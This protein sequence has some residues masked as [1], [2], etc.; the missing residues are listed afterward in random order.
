MNQQGATQ[1]LAEYAKAVHE[2]HSLITA[3]HP[4]TVSRRGELAVLV[5]DW[6]VRGYEEKRIVA[7]LKYFRES[8]DDK[9]YSDTITAFLRD[10]GKAKKVQS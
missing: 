8:A 10:Y 9:V 1:A 7:T 3:M 2:K 5:L 4:Y 6:L